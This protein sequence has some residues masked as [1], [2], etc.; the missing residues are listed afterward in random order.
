MGDYWP[1]AKKFF[2]TSGGASSDTKKGAMQK[3]LVKAGIQQCNIIEV[4]SVLDPDANEISYYKKSIPHA[5]FAYSVFAHQEGE[6]GQ[7]IGAGVGVAWMQSKEGARKAY[8]VEASGYK[9]EWRVKRDVLLSLVDIAEAEKLSV[10][11]IPSAQATIREPLLG[12][13]EWQSKL[14]TEG[15]TFEDSREAENAYVRYLK[16]N[17]GNYFRLATVDINGI[18][19]DYGYVA[20]ALVYVLD[21]AHIPHC[22]CSGNVRVLKDAQAST[23]HQL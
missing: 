14:K 8:V 4:S 6:E 5:A 15:R 17:A 21:T 22:D 2:L 18:P 9:T 20:A 13:R 19:E 1:V 12:R 16:E 11:P 3:A 7:T 10:T 23:N